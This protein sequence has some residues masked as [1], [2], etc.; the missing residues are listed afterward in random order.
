[1]RSKDTYP[2]SIEP[3]APADLAGHDG[4]RSFL[5]TVVGAIAGGAVLS[6]R[7]SSGG[8]PEVS[9]VGGGMLGMQQPLP[10]S[11]ASPGASPAG[12][13]M[14]PTPLPPGAPAE[15][16]LLYKRFA[17][18]LKV[19]QH[20]IVPG[21][22]AHMMG[23]DS[24]VPGPTFRVQ[25]GDWVWVD[26]LN[27]SDEMHTIHWHGLILDYR[28]DGVPYL[29]QDPVMRGD[30]YRYVF[31]AKPYGTHFYHCHFGTSMHMQAGMYGAFIVE[32]ADDPIHAKFPYTQDYT[33]VL[34]SIDTV[35]VRRQ[36][37]A[38]FAR[39]R[40]RDVLAAR[41]ALDARTQAVF[42]SLSGLKSLR[43][44]IAAGY[45]PPY[46]TA[47]AVAEPPRPNFFTINGKAYPATETIRVRRG[48]WTRVRFI[49]AGNVGFSMHLH[50]HD[51]YWVCSDG[52]PLP[53][54]VR[55]NTIRIEPGNTQ[56]MVFLADNPGFW[57]LHDHEVTHTTNNGVY[58]GG[59]MTH[60]AYEGFEGAYKPTV[61]LDE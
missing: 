36:M 53:A 21:I 25:E 12:M 52:A 60:V 29:G 6:A 35:F 23:Y 5:K 51:F 58:P 32:N 13:S 10:G 27:S 11:A 22:V 16:S 3:S 2:N 14:V 9:E 38:M 50:G 56:D 33:L 45:V 34:S 55:L 37:N 42:K 26:F 18:E 4:R 57:A 1:M 7:A 61:S 54:P 49:N 8:E 20:E 19:V 46:A 24:S 47:R 48:E 28:M 31:Q 40:Q 44:A 59:A 39:M 43:N 30:R 41:G 15:G 17:L